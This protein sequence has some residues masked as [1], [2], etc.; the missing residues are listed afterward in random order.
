MKSTQIW[1]LLCIIPI[2]S[3]AQDYSSSPNKRPVAKAVA[4]TEEPIID[5]E[6]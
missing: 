6:V 2:I 1:A 3:A 5:G 4:I